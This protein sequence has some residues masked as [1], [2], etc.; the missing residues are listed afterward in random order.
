MV[1]GNGLLANAFNK[2]K[3]DD[4]ILIFASGVSNSGTTHPEEFKREFNLIQHHS[5]HCRKFIYFST[6]SIFDESLLHTPYIKHKL[7]IEDYLVKNLDRYIIFRLPIVVGKSKN[8][9]TLTNHIYHQL[10]HHQKLTIFEKACRYLMD[11]DDVSHFLISMIDNSR[12]DN[13]LINVHL[14][15][16]LKVTRLVELFEETTGLIAEKEF[17]NKGSCYT[18]DASLFL[19]WINNKTVDAE[20]YAVELIK[21][22]YC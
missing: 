16:R 5:G 4:E 20:Q 10:R 12:F 8:I 14:N 3:D 17:V 18:A 1:I 19:N 11:I 22:Y 6:I 2:Y 9:H 7:M 13:N 15:N 21:K